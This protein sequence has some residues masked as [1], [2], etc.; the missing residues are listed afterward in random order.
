MEKCN[1]DCEEHGLKDLK[2][3]Y[4]EIQKKH[5]LPEFDALNEDFQIE[6]LSDVETDFLVREVRRF[7]ADKFSNYLRFI[8]AI[9]NPVNAQ[10]FVFSFIKTLGSVEREKLSSVYKKLAKKEVD[11]IELDI[12]FSE[13]KEADFVKDSFLIWQDLKKD[14]MDVVD[15]VKANWDKE[16]E[17]NGSGKGYFG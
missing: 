12:L 2:E 9:L 8:E 7:I 15:V 17:I 13:E 6:K 5:S 4:L 16:V 14:L 10:M 1:S 11:V 3:A